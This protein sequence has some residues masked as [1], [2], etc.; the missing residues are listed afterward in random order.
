MPSCQAGD[1]SELAVYY[2]YEVF[3]VRFLLFLY[4]FNIVMSV[5]TFKKIHVCT[6]YCNPGCFIV[7]I[8]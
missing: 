8:K 3:L 1:L 4:A 2:F 7:C 5:F 6:Q